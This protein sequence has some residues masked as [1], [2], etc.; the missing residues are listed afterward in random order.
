MF[1]KWTFPCELAFEPNTLQKRPLTIPTIRY[2]RRDVERG[3]RYT[4]KKGILLV[5]TFPPISTCTVYVYRCK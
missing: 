3:S 1:K 4:N 2:V 5:V